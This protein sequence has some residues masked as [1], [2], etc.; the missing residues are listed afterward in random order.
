MNHLTER[1]SGT[2]RTT[3]IGLSIGCLTLAGCT[4]SPTST[5]AKSPGPTSTP[6]ATT[7]ATPK[8]DT[9]TKTTPTK[10][11]TRPAPPRTTVQVAHAPPQVPDTRTTP[12]IGPNGLGGLQLGMTFWQAKAAGFVR[13]NESADRPCGTYDLYFHG[14]RYGRVFISPDR[15]VEAIGSELPV[16]TPEGVTIGTPAARAAAV[17]PDLDV[18]ELRQ[19]GRFRVRVPGNPDARYR[20]GFQQH[21]GVTS[22]ALQRSDQGCY[23]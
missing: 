15:G 13:G 4:S 7:N 9:S 8:I 21:H 16:R 19:L 11:D 23:E 5:P 6:A 18:D 2:I 22:I 20:L 10:A 17:Y 14:A 12:R 1:L 3:I